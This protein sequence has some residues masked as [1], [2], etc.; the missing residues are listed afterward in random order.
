[1]RIIYVGIAEMRIAKSPLILSTLGLG[2]CVGATL[3]DPRL[4]IGGLV[5]ILLPSSNGETP[6]NRAKYADS[7]IPELVERMI[8]MG[9]NRGALVAKIAG[10][11]NMFS[12]AGSSNAFIIGQKNVEACLKALKEQRIRLASSDTGGS[13]GRSIEL[14]TENGL[15]LIKTIG[16]GTKYI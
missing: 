12:T 9:S 8:S 2:S 6:A 10:G 13:Y 16:H 5:H 1:M 3:F 7:G 11:A 4:Q 15:L 14:N